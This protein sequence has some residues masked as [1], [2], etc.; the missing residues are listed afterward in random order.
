MTE[1]KKNNIKNF[2]YKLS[3]ILILLAAISYI[4]N[5]LIARYIIILGV[6]GFTI[7]TFMTPYPGKSLRGKRLYNIHVFGIVFMVMSAYLMFVQMNEW[8]VP[9]LISGVLICYSSILLPK[10]YREEQKKADAKLNNK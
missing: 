5:P 4:Y 1:L 10:V 9:M 8:V 3:S 2:I 6:A 7:T